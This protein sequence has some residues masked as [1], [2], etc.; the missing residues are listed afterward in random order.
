MLLCKNPPRNSKL[1]KVLYNRIFEYS[2]RKNKAKGIPEYS[3]LNPETNSDSASGRSKGCR[4]VSAT[5]AI[6]NNIAKIGS[7]RANQI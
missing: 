4:L 2:P 1:S 3:T 7:K 5:Q 6:K